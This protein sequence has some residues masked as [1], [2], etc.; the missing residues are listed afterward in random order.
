MI[1]LNPV[2]ISVIVMI[3]LC[4]INLNIVLALLLAALAGGL[5]AGMSIPATM[6]VLISGMGGNAAAGGQDAFSGN[7]AAQVFRRGF[8]TDQQPRSPVKKSRRWWE[9][10]RL[11]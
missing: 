5:A 4:L 9:S 10:T 8:Q 7:H 3:G 1:L 2:V 6:G 11:C